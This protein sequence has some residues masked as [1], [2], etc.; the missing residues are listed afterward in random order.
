MFSARVEPA[1]SL[2]AWRIAARAA[3]C[4]NV[5]PDQV[6]WEGGAQG[7]LLA[8]PEVTTLPAQREAPRVSSDFLAL[9]G[10]VLCHRDPHRHGLLYRLLWRMGQGERGLLA[11][12]TDADV[13]RAG[14]LAKAVRRDSHKMKAFVRFREVPGEANAF[15]AWFEPEHHIV[16]RVAPFFARRFAGMRWAILTPYRSAHWDGDALAF[17]PGGVRADAPADDAREALWRTY[18]ANIFN[19]A[20]LNPTMMRSEMPQKYWKHLPEAAL[21][22]ELLQSA[23]ARVREMAERMPEAPRRRIPEAAPEPVL[24]ADDSLDAV[25]AAAAAC[26]RCELWQPATRTVFGEGP[27]DARIVL[28]G[29]QPGDEEDLSGRPFVGPAGK[30]LDRVLAELG[31]DRGAL[32]LTNAVKHFR[33]EQRGKRRLHRNPTSSQVAACRPWLQQELARLDPKAI[34]CLGANAAR[35]VLGADFQLMAQRGQWRVMA[36]GA[37]A[38]ATVHPSWVLRQPDAKAR[39]DAY[40]LLRQDLALLVP[41]VR[42]SA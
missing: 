23:G 37:R 35:A 21:L 31:I 40:A 33:F 27:A 1:W 39:E 42:A 18:Y 2:E 25:R 26:R 19:P 13:H 14:V 36:D 4:A 15:V 22:P 7:G 11:H 34:V 20:R 9:A 3:W 32:Y 28:V 30:L 8:T 12:A 16:D 41:D 6:D 29:E 38:L 10:A 17:G 5:A 24:R